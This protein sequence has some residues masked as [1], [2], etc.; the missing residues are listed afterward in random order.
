MPAVITLLL[1]GLAVIGGVLD[2]KT[3]R[4]PN[5]LALAGLGAGLLTNSI[6]FGWAGFKLSA[7]G[8][9]LAFAVYLFF[10]L[11]RVMGAG[12]VKFMAAIGAIVGPH[13]WLLILFFTALSG[14]VV[15]LIVLVTKGS[16]RRTLR[17]VAMMLYQLSR[18]QAPYHASE[19]LDVRSE[20]AVRLPH[21]A[22]IAL[23]I[24]V[25]LFA[26]QFHKS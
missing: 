18:F 16:F 23:G 10:Y 6:L 3:R 17:N 15:A 5:W 4:L 13:L 22:T 21:G 24:I 12:D 7:S 14:G 26:G 19:Q 9:G 25:Y 2:L 1:V 20:R 8:A 11:L